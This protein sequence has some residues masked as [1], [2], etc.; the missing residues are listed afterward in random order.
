MELKPILQALMKC[1]KERL[2]ELISAQQTEIQSLKEQVRTLKGQLPKTSQNSHKPPSSDGYQKPSPK[3]QRVKSGRKSGGQP[4][5]KGT[6]LEM[7][8]EIDRVEL[9]GVSHCEHCG[10]GLENSTSIGYERRQEF[11]IPK[12]VPSVKEHRA[13]IKR[14]MRCGFINKGTFPTH[15]NQATQYGVRIKAVAS[16]LHHY[17]LIPYGRVQ[18]LL[19]DLYS[20]SF[21]EGTLFNTAKTCYETLAGVSAQIKQR[22]VQ[23]A[24]AHF[25]ENRATRYGEIAMV[26]CVIYKKF[27][28]LCIA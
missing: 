28:P 24:Y 22:L 8:D 23:S 5:H 25:D 11:D 21:S 20:I 18:E 4:G 1:S 16:Y 26:I 6:T 14:C 9:Y 27:N 3:S 15:V 7:V 2:I 13:E 19:K 17:Q 10:C 12:I